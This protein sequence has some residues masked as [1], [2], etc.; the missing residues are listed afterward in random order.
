[1]NVHRRA[2][3]AAGEQAA[4]LLGQI[5]ELE[6]RAERL[7]GIYAKRSM[8]A[9]DE[10]G[11]HV[12]IIA[13][14]PHS[15]TS[16]TVNRRKQRTSEAVEAALVAFDRLTERWERTSARINSQIAHLLAELR[17][18]LRCTEARERGRLVARFS[19]WL[20]KTK[21]RN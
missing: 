12:E 6:E 16:E 17:P 9:L 14:L 18:A 3:I 21:G 8:A 10:C 2:K 5:M 19:F 1:V 11:K 4:E 20:Q 7:Q 13:T 15:N